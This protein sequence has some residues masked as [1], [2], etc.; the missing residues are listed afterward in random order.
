MSHVSYSVVVPTVGRPELARLLGHLAAAEGPLPDQVVVVDDRPERVRPLDVAVP[1]PLAGRLRLLGGSGRGPAGARNIGWR[2]VRS[3]W[4]AFL[5][6][7]VVPSATWRRDLA[8]DLAQ[9]PSG[10]AG[11]QGRVLV[12]LPCGVRPTDWERTT[13]GLATARWITADMAYRRG[14]LE[15]VG[16]F[17]E[18]FRR[19]YREDADLALR[20]RALGHDLTRGHRLVHH[21]VRPAGRWVSLRAQAGNADDV[22]MQRLHGVRW[23]AHVGAPRGRFPAHRNATAALGLAV[24]FAAGR[25]PA[26]AALAAAGW[27]ALT[28]EFAWAR[29]AP[30]PRTRDEVLTMLATSIAIPPVAVFHRLAGMWR[31]RAVGSWPAV[32]QAVLL[33]RDGTLVEDVPYNGDPEQVHPVAGAREALDRLRAA[34]VRLGVV[35][36]QSGIGRGL[37]TA[38]QVAA[39]NRRIVEDLGPFDVWEQC[40]HAPDV[41]CD[42]R[43]PRPAL[44][45]RAARR[46]D[47]P[48]GACAVVGDIGSDVEAA[49]RAGARPVLVPTPVTRPQEVAA[50]PEVAGNLAEAVDL[51]L[52]PRDGGPV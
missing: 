22:L 14:V 43:K 48:V 18:R 20:V 45:R 5:D 28:G 9:A 39:V 42:C 52:A 21:P 38:H 35:T 40:P 36:N 7:D 33:D 13:A 11:S 30:G 4:V 51:L 32:P 41:G 44:I 25:R 8:A 46:L 19:A 2:A 37:V 34:G 27:A 10:T 49:L 16:G 47:V 24:L 26:P 31:H 12:P 3:P 15:R 29:I 50:A 17:D 6:D 23:R 1:G